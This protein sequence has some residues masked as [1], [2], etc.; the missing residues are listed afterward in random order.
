MR[1][2]LLL[3]IVILSLLIAALFAAGS[4]LENADETAS[5]LSGLSSDET[6]TGLYQ[7][8]LIIQDSRCVLKAVVE[9]DLYIVKSTVTVGE[10]G[11][12]SGDVYLEDATLFTSENEI[13]AEY[14]Q[15]PG[16]AVA[17]TSVNG[18][19]ESAPFRTSS[20]GIHR[21]IP[22]RIF[23]YIMIFLV[24]FIIHY[25]LGDR[26]AYLK[27]DFGSYVI[28]Y[29]F[30]GLGFYVLLPVAILLLIVTIIGIPVL[31]FMSILFL[32]ALFV[33]FLITLHRG[34]VLVFPSAR[35]PWIFGFLLYAFVDLLLTLL[36]SGFSAPAF[37]LFYL[38]F[39]SCII[40]FSTGIS[41]RYLK[42]LMKKKK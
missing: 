30:V 2:R 18:R 31:I 32:F 9:G 13:T 42:N 24:L 10:G 40:L 27:E 7:G 20:Q 36:A 17:K 37:D 26:I 6:V 1:R 25:L 8:D 23:F 15:V 22:D 34:G 19:S 38:L 12:V 35:T 33:G 28:K 29:F 3:L 11:S 5:M 41:L 21:A 16:S 14:A 39:I 4:I